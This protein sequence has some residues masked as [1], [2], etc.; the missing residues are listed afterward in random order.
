MSGLRRGAA[1]LRP[2]HRPR[3]LLRHSEGGLCPRNLSWIVR[4][5]EIPHSADSVRNG[6]IGVGSIMQR[7]RWAATQRLEKRRQATA[8]HN[9]GMPTFKVLL[10]VSYWNGS[11]GFA[12][13]LRRDKPAA[14]RSGR[15]LD[16]QSVVVDQHGVGA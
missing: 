8:I 16:R 6:M 7:E 3:T 12:P 1:L 11:S 14:T 2:R 9:V 10:E 5:G 4:D 13:L 15:S